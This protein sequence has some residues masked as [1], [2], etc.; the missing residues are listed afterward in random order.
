MPNQRACIPCKYP[1][2]N[3]YLKRRMS[4]SA[5]LRTISKELGS[6]YRMKSFG[7]RKG[8]TQSMLQEHLHSHLGTAPVSG[9]LPSFSGSTTPSSVTTADGDVATGIQRA[10]LE[11]LSRGE[12]RVTAA[13]AL[14]AQEMIDRRAE[15]AADRELA[16]VLARIL[17]SQA[18]P[19]TH[20]IDPDIIIDVTPVEE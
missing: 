2:A 4:E 5:D 3:D 7:Y 13:N 9:N 10:A 1:Q 19:P 16:L 20:L 14:K 6:P 8:P 17:T 12:L 18:E 15:K 11:A